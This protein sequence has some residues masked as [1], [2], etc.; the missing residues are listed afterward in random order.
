[1]NIAFRTDSSFTI[2][3]G[4][5]H[6]CLNLARK[7]KKRDSKCYFFT[8]DYPGNINKLIQNE[9]DI[10]KLSTKFSKNFYTKNQNLTDANLTIKFIKKLDIDIIF[11]DNYLIKESWEKKVSKFTKI[12]LISDFI[13]RKSYC[14]FYI[15]YNTFCE[16]FS[17]SKNLSKECIKL[18]GT[19]YL[20][21]KDLYHLKK[22]IEKKITVFMGGADSKNYTSKLISILSDKLFLN[23][24]KVIIIG[25]KNTKTKL[26]IDRIKKLKNFKFF[27][28]N[29]K[30]LYSFFINSKLVITGLGISMY[31][32]L[33]LGLNSIVI[34]QNNLQKK[35]M[36]NLSLIDSINFINDKKKLNKNHIY[37][38]LSEEHSL[39]KKLYLQNLY[40]SRGSDRIVDYF[41]SKNIL[42]NLKLEEATYN[43]KFFLYKLVN[44]AQAIKNS[45]GN[46]FISLKEHEK[47]FKKVMKKKNSKIYICRTSKHRIGQVRLDQVSKK[48]NLITYSVANEFRG[49]N[50]GYKMLNLALKNKF[51]EK[52]EL[53]AMVK[54]NNKV[55]NYIFK[56]IGF[57]LIKTPTKNNN[58]Y[59]LK[60]N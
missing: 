51:Y 29:K 25:I 14:N 16:D 36:K 30:N 34:I 10:F 37:K 9:F 15:N 52:K 49:K 32:H 13:N 40:N 19:D 44:D 21:T 6:R 22:K 39:K 57:E 33:I 28:G 24:K 46:K 2:G 7:F 38:I 48:K 56:K 54:K 8:N 42:K 45:L 59:Y 50:I 5:V 26:L 20:I 60:N 43:D 18:I 12:V 11:L 55:S 58:I 1:M 23:F 4:H 47:W 27:I 17:I 35:V 31:E 3:T 53:Y 41:L